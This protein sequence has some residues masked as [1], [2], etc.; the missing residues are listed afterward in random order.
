ML[1]TSETCGFIFEALTEYTDGCYLK[2]IVNFLQMTL[3]YRICRGYL[4]YL[5]R[6]NAT[7]IL[8]I[9]IYGVLKTLLIYK[10]QEY[11]FQKFVL[12]S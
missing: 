8:A 12:Q 4:R 3:S 11:H 6:D 7:T 2:M 5:K 10:T 9:K 1:D